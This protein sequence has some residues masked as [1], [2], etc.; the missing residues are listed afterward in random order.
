[1]RIIIDSYAWV[2]Y[3]LGSDKGRKARKIIEKEGNELFTPDICMAEIKFWALR[4]KKDFEEIRRV[5]RTNSSVMESF[6][7]DWL[8][9]AQ[10]KFE[11]RKK[12]K[13]FGLVDAL[14]VVKQRQLG[15]AILTGDVH[16]RKGKRVEFL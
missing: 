14:L 9:A 10:V 5:I 1:M 7:N 3:F 8:E 2:E 13:S 12:S 15:S 4:E 11:K 6:S 16:F